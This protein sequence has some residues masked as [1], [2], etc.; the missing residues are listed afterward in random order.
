MAQKAGRGQLVAVAAAAEAPLG[1]AGGVIAAAA[2]AE[3]HADYES[4][5][6]VVKKCTNKS[7]KQ[8]NFDEHE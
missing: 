1:S 7:Y 6:K 5:E 3:C 8:N 2:R 4:V